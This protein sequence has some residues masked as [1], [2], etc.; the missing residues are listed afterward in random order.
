MSN[1]PRFTHLDD[2]EFQAVRRVGQGDRTMSV[3]EKWLDFSPAYLSLYAKWDPGM[4][5]Q[6]HGHNSDHVVFVIEGDIMCGETHC[7]AGTHIALDQGDI[8]GPFVAGPNGC[9][10][11]EI[12]MG[13]PRSFP[14]DLAEYEK[15]LAD[16][17]VQQL[18]NPPIDMP[19]WLP[20][21]RN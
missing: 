21:T 13:D 1:S 15:F 3:R 17:G 18:P 5:V 19:D 6:P 9:V 20:D 16:N 8:F 4:I 7:P 10:L 11:F 14:G 2:H 12:M